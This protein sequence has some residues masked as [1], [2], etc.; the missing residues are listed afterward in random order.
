MFQFTGLPPQNLFIQ[1][2]VTRHYPG[3][4]SP[5]G[6]LGIDTSVQLPRAFRRFRVLRRQL[7]PRHSSHTFLSFDTRSSI[8]CSMFHFYS[9]YAT[10]KERSR[11]PARLSLCRSS[12]SLSLSFRRSTLRRWQEIWYQP[13]PPVS[14]VDED[15]LDSGRLSGQK[16][17]AFPSVRVRM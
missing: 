12:G 15:F 10:V 2:W 6:Y 13:R 11:R 17:L 8:E 14:R 3:R 1:F 16:A 7:V 5:F 9:L 4:V